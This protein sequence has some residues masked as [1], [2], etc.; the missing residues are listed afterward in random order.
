M[1]NLKQ[2]RPTRAALAKAIESRVERMDMA[3]LLELAVTL[4]IPIPGSDTAIRARERAP[5]TPLT[6][7]SGPKD[8]VLQGSG[9]GP[10]VS[11]AEGAQMLD[12]VTV[13]NAAA[14]WIES[15]LVG[16]GQLVHQLH[17]SRGTLDNWRKANKIV[18]LRKGLRNFV[19]PLRQFERRRPVE[20][21]DAIAPLFVSPEEAWEWL[22]TPNRMTDGKPP[23][24][25]L[26]DGDVTLV[27]SAAEGASDYT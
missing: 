6:Q 10:I 18:A 27:L 17:I 25:K 16:A 15:D 19:Y 8:K 22:V 13:D 14:D 4:N 1:V 3:G 9:V 7:P 5:F 20:G 21:L 24:D 12:M 11:A 23:I 26:H 2:T